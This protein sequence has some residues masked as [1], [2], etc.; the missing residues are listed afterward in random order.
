VDVS[1]LAHELAAFLAV[2][3][4]FE[5][6]NDWKTV[7]EILKY[8]KGGT[9]VIPLSQWNNLLLSLN[10]LR[11][12]RILELIGRI[13]TGN[14][15]WEIKPT[16]LNETLSASWLE[17]KNMEI[18]EALAG[19]MDSQRSAQISVLVNEVFGAAEVTRLDYYTP[20]KGKILA[21]KDLDEYVYA[22]ALNHLLAFIQDY[23]SKE[24][25][26]LCDILLIRG[27]WTNVS[28]SRQMSGGLHDVLEITPEIA[29]LD[30]GLDD[31]G[32]NGARLRG[33]LLR[34]DRDRSQNRYINS[35]IDGINEEALNILNRA[36]ASLII[37]GKHFKM[38]MDDYSKKPFELIMNWKELTLA[39]KIPISQRITTAYKRINY[40][41]QLMIL[42]TKATE[43]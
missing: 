28:A 27:Q 22:P 43:E 26:E 13:S 37:V 23:I 12:S 38:L 7:F 31:D 19:I 8:C 5:E 34:I 30:E 41:V 33:A 24:I 42:E 17:Y 1:L 21:N 39:S 20:E 29:K 6:D 36:S 40:C 11:K 14:P 2:L 9:D 35:I 3:P 15:I 25:Q 4:S 32:G 10:D 16:L 18:R